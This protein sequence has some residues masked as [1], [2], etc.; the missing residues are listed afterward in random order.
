MKVIFTIVAFF[1]M[2]LT[3]FAQE[4]PLPIIDIHLHANSASSQGPP[5]LGFCSPAIWPTF[6]PGKQPWGEVFADW[7]KNPPC[8]NPIWS[9][10]TDDE[11]MKKTLE[12]LE[13]RNIIGVTSGPLVHKYQSTAPN[14]II[15]G[16]PLYFIRSNWPSVDTVRAWIESGR[17]AFFGE[18]AIQ[19]RGMEP[20]DTAFEPYLALAEELD[21][22]V[23]IH[24]GTG[25]PGV[26]YMW[27]KNYRARLHSPLLLED[28]LVRHPKLRIC[29]M[30]AGWPMIDDLLAVLWTHPQAYV[31]VGVIVYALPPAEFYRY[32]RRI[33]ESGFGKRV[34]FGSDQMVW[35][36]AIER[37]LEVIEKAD[38]LTH[39]QKRDI[40]YNNAARFLRLSEEEIKAH[41]GLSA[42]E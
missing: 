15:A 5:P 16:L 30:H 32:L 42:K 7:M 14:R 39:E 21:V 22:P 19:Y 11:L 38:F 18:V 35:P 40:L 41:H 4:P 24:I 12:I 28:A 26:P 34:M 9:P 36:G 10:M 20:G 8:D 25:P 31:G 33:V 6:D 1:L 17:L 13:R 2:F 3:T 29:I 37:A 27:G 23:G